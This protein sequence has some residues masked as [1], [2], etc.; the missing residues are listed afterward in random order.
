MVS[1]CIGRVPRLVASGATRR[2]GWGEG[3]EGV[4]GEEGVEGGRGE[5]GGRNQNSQV[6]FHQGARRS[7][8]ICNS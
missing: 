4:E 3:V 1:H 6:D 2:G 8:Y 5:R 7:H